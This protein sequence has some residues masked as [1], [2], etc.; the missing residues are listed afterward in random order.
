[1]SNKKFGLRKLVQL[2]RKQLDS[3]PPREDGSLG[4]PLDWDEFNKLYFS[5]RHVIVEYPF[6]RPYDALMLMSFYVVLKIAKT[7][8][9]IG[10]CNYGQKNGFP[11]FQEFASSI[12]SKSI[13][14]N[15]VFHYEAV[16]P[17]P[18]KH[19]EWIMNADATPSWSFN[20][21]KNEASLILNEI[22]NTNG[23]A[24]YEDNLFDNSRSVIGWEGMKK[25]KAKKVV[26][27]WDNRDRK[28]IKW[29]MNN[30][31]DKFVV[32][33]YSREKQMVDNWFERNETMVDPGFDMK[34]MDPSINA[35]KALL[36]AATNHIY[37][38]RKFANVLPEVVSQHFNKDELRELL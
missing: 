4:F 13:S 11:Y 24:T 8:A 30:Y 31:P 23:F 20:G 21:Y 6:N 32:I 16:P 25:P 27:A 2:R 29:V 38:F 7:D 35:R 37:D 22:R 12:T 5:K 15:L 9:S 26:I 1:M 3:S 14:N 18:K 10:M 36:Y 33:P 28:T 17:N 34:L 19:D